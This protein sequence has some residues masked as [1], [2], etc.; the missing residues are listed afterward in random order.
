MP[1]DLPH[2]HVDAPQ[3]RQETTL[4]PSG[5]G[6]ITHWVVP[7]V[8]DN[9]PAKGTTHQVLIDPRD[10]TPAHVKQAIIESL[11][12]VHGVASLNSRDA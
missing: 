3:M 2:W 11:S 7:Y 12:S 9:G 1:N 8:I 6:L 5:A 4:A 10:Y